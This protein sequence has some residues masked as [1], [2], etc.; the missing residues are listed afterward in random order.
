MFTSIE[1][2]LLEVHRRLF[3]CF[4]FRCER[5]MGS[6]PILLRAGAR[7]ECCRHAVRVGGRQRR[8]ALRH[9]AE[10]GRPAGRSRR[11]RARQR[12]RPPA[13]GACRALLR[14]RNDHLGVLCC[15]V[16][17]ALWCSTNVLVHYSRHFS[18]LFYITL[19]LVANAQL[20]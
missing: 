7:V 17:Y 18:T 4:E 11:R 14:A 10:P 1:W 13:D 3:A 9:A 12:R 20:K 8:P 16:L 6:S 2:N 5:Q 19:S 15:A